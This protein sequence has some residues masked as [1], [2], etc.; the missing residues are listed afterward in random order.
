MLSQR[1]HI[2]HGVSWENEKG[3]Q[4]KPFTLITNKEI[5]DG[6]WLPRDRSK[7]AHVLEYTKALE[8]QGRFTLCIWPEHCLIG[9]AGHNV[10]PVLNR[11]LQEWAYAR[12][13]AITYVNKG[14]NCDTE[15]YSAIKAEFEIAE[16][17]STQAN[18]ELL[19]QLR[20]ADKVGC[21]VLLPPLA[22]VHNYNYN[23]IKII[24]L[25]Y[26]FFVLYYQLLLVIVVAG[27]RSSS[28]SLCAIHLFGHPSYMARR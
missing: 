17:K 4:P 5:Q 20:S 13:R 6:V 28:V 14:T 23:T 8:A 21:V 1:I 26:S 25:L 24:Y 2:A 9:T 22:V 27:M 7:L 18:A 3:E 12:S 15:M 11:A 19:S 10:V 16:D